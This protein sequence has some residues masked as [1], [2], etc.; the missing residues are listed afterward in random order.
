ML[1]VK[2]LTKKFDA[3]AA[4]DNISFT[5]KK[6]EIVGFLGTNGAG[7][8]TTM[9]LIT[10]FLTPT[11][12]KILI[13]KKTP[14]AARDL[15]GY[16]PEE[17]PLY[18][19]YTPLEYLNFIGQM[20]GRS[21]QALK[22]NIHQVVKDCDLAS[23]LNQTI[24]TLSRGFRQRVG[25]AATLVHQPSLIIM[26]EPTTGLDPNQQ[27]EIRKLIKTI[28]KDKGVILSTHYLTEA[29]EVC[30]RIIIIHQGKIMID[31]KT[32]D[33]KKERQSLENL[34]AKLTLS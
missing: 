13:N 7:K 18:S 23:V 16:L 8:T 3:I 6:G 21:P 11:S 24:E 10:G 4:V 26:D 27:K 25:L 2:N 15:I 29:R 28:A 17:N 20:F 12:G 9:R 34:F 19:K 5:L 33:L 22:K 30:D 32:A 14:K 1:T 31:K